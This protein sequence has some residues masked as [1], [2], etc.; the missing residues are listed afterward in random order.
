MTECRTQQLT[1]FYDGMV[2]LYNNISLEKAQAFMS[3]MGS[4]GMQNWSS[5]TNN[6]ELLSSISNTPS[7]HISKR[8]SQRE[9]PFA[10]KASLARFLKSRKARVEESKISKGNT[11]CTF[12]KAKSHEQPCLLGNRINSI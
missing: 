1:I 10:R 9:L 8:R 6:N 4:Q 7:E 12:Q 5:L 3:L 2:Y 11:K